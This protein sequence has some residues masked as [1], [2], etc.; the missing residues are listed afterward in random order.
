MFL[1][2]P[3]SENYLR[4]NTIR[5]SS[6]SKQGQGL[7]LSNSLWPKMRALGNCCF[8]RIKRSSRVSRCAW[9]RVSAGCPFS[10]RPPS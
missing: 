7:D 9:V 8:R 2:A 1:A 6:A 10:S 5:Y 3:K 4:E